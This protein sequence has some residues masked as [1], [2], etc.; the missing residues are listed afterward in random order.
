M[1][2]DKQVVFATKDD[3]GHFFAE[4]IDITPRGGGL[5]KIA[6]ARQP[7][8]EAFIRGLRPDPAFQY[9]LMTPMGSFEYWGQN[10]N[11]D[12]FP[13]LALSFDLERDDPVQRAKAIEAKW[14]SPLGVELPHGNYNSFGFRTFEQAN[15]YRH[16][17]NKNPELSYGSIPIAVWNP[18]MHRVEVI[19]RHDREKAKLVGAAQIITDIDEGKPR[20]ISMGCRTP[21]DICSKCGHLSRTTSD[22][23]DC[24]KY[25]MG[26]TLPNGKVIGAIN[27]FPR[28][29][30]LSDV[31]VPAAKESGVLEKVASAQV[32]Q[33]FAKKAMQTKKADID[34]EVMP[35]TAAA[36]VNRMACSEP[37]LP[38]RE[39]IRGSGDPA[40]LLTTLA[41]LGIVAKPE[42]FQY[43]LLCRMG[44]P[45]VAQ[46]L[47]DS[48]SVFSP[49]G[50][51]AASPFDGGMYSPSL[52]RVLA[53]FLP[54]RS[55]FYP[56][57]PARAMRITVMRASP[58]AS[59]QQVPND[60]L[61]NK[62]ASAYASYRAAFRNLPALAE[63]A[64][65]KDPEYYA[66]NFF[67]DLLPDAMTKI[68]SSYRTRVDSPGVTTYMY[69]AYRGGV[70]SAPEAWEF[71]TS[72]FSPV[73]ALLGPSF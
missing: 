50:C 17:V 47:A 6:G 2:I 5:E 4:A 21:F 55:G 43:A 13:E 30:D 16:H 48:G 45:Q 19:V 52:A 29:F 56:H 33:G 42:E 9:V 38:I 25:Q 31:I 58:V 68:A 28:F 34:K 66:R 72:P 8:I 67:S 36:A 63:I 39:L 10:V 22:Y 11:G 64:Y 18:V 3:L 27:P 61:L 62:V 54:E 46:G 51:S 37:N 59:A 32:V 7:Q 40:L 69:G 70:S 60:D 26:T 57:L 35:N 44:K 71:T 20:L 41:A 14:L 1:A 49:V 15:R 12:Q 23:C 53:P 73:R 24:L 65:E